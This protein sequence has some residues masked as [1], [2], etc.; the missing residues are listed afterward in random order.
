MFHRMGSAVRILERSSANTPES[1]LAGVGLGPD[2]LHLLE[3]FDRM[4]DIPLGIP[5]VQLQSL[6]RNGHPRPFLK[7][8]RVLSSWDALYFRLRAN[9]DML[10]SDYVPPLN[11]SALDGEDL[12]NATM[13]A[14]YEVGKQVFNVKELASGQL[15]VHY[16]DLLNGGREEQVVAD[17]VIGADGP[18]SLI[19]KL[20]T[21]PD[22][23]ERKY[24]GYIA[25]RGVVAED[26]VSERTR[27]IFS[28]NI[29]Y[30][31]LEKKAGH[32]IV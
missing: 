27:E 9:F 16:R 24:A 12:E 31:I 26:Q 6:D 28:E 7:A 21:G 25:W 10:A 19:R 30:S 5:S 14:K 29:T 20:F 3:R 13:R 32:V 23:S 1:H 11:P 17:M 2:A 4:R 18:N 8:R 15:S 22:A